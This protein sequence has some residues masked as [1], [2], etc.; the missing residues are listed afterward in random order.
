M[1]KI[2][3]SVVTVLMLFIGY[4]WLLE[5]SGSWHPVTEYRL[6]SPVKKV[7]HQQIH[8]ALTPF[9][10]QSFWKMDLDL[11]QANLTRLD[12]V[13]S[14]D[15]KRQWPDKLLVQI[16][17]QQPVVRWKNAALLNKHGEVF[18]PVDIETFAH[19]V[20]LSGAE[21]RSRE[22]LKKLSGFQRAFSQLNWVIKH[23]K[24]HADGVWQIEFVDAPMVILDQDEWQHKLT[25]FIA[26]YSKIQV[27]VRNRASQFDL[28][29]SNGFVIK[30][31]S[32]ELEQL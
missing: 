30:Q 18:Y 9:M 1:K 5:S 26:A 24:E 2:A 3:V 32:N 4:G 21:Q 20:K 7:N 17:E 8:Q 12:W 28:R 29:Y 19:F 11:I 16:D 22:L 31:K 14:A 27:D 15:V 6:L 25:R 23:L 13:Y 10:G